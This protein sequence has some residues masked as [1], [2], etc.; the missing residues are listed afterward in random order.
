M[1]WATLLVATCSG[2]QLPV[3]ETGLTL[4]QSSL[5]SPV[6][7]GVG[8]WSWG[9]RLLWQYSEE[10]DDAIAATWRAAVDGGVTFF[11][12]GDSYGTGA[13]EGR[14]ETLLG[15]CRER[16]GRGIFGP[17]RLVYGTKL[18]VYPWR[19]SPES[20]VDALRY[21][22]SRLR[23]DCVEIAQAHWSARNYFPPQD[24]SLLEGLAQ[25][26][27]AGLCD[28]VGLSNFGPR[29]LRDAAKFF[30]DR[31]VPVALNQVQ[32]SLLSTQPEETGLL[33][34][35]RDLG[36]TPVAYSP[37]ALGAL[38][39]VEDKPTG[40]RALLFDQVLPGASRLT[41][42][43]SDIAQTRAKTPAQVALNW[44]ISKGCFPIVG[45]RTPRRIQE[46]L[47]ACGWRLSDAEV[48]A[49]DDA[50]RAATRKATQNIF[51][52]S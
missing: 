32:F 40:P 47:G 23:L 7:L 17:R 2:F 15:E 20:F 31:G 41:G 46:N 48:R 8:T 14:A 19:Q 5:R 35:C 4:G 51:M 38:A 22:L 29:A 30:E 11:D 44:T 10:Q 45:A 25:S 26:Y 16:Y 37:L 39:A 36:I 34:V 28:A 3:V 13:L 1:W 18:A 27:E 42:L 49:L 33:D 21:S 43:L 52:T 24:A 12:T 9:N 50:A 6:P